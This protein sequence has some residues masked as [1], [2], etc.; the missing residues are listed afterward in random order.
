MRSCSLCQRPENE[1]KQL[2]EMTGGACICNRCVATAAGLIGA[3][4]KQKKEEDAPLLKP[5][6]IHAALSDYVIGQEHAK[7]DISVAIYNHYKRREA[8]KHGI[9]FEVEIQKS[10]ILI[11]GPTGSGKTELARTIAKK[12]KVPLFVGDATKLTS[13]GYVGDDVE[14]LLQGLMTTCGNDVE[15]AEW[16][17]VF[18]D[19]VDKI[20]R[21][22]GKSDSGF[23]DVSGEAVQQ[24]LL[25][26]LEGNQVSV[27]RAGKSG[28]GGEYDI[29]DTSNILFICAGSFAGIEESVNRRKNSGASLGFGGQSR[30][31]FTGTDIYMAVEEDDIL[32]F[33]IIPE[34]LGRIPVRTTTVLLTEDEMVRI[35]TEPKNALIKQFQALFEM[36]G[37]DLQFDEEA[38]KAIGR[39]AIK[40]P[41]GARALRSIVERILKPYAYDSP[42]DPSIKGI[43]VTKEVV[44]GTGTAAILTE[45]SEQSEVLTVLTASI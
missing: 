39:E 36:D 15:K 44:E 12:L 14:S 7:K 23:R 22:S 33:G 45:S 18:L 25:K 31:K 19:E 35:L 37:I 21:K 41:T 6:E 9:N 16:G 32:D 40:R 43:R 2:V 11:L 17:I 20:A 10:N 30:T 26:M 28:M 34:M 8:L 24:A 29:L 27:P 42:S 3:S 5:K 38:L 4:P 1:V 13:S